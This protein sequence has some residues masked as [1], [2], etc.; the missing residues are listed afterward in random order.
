MWVLPHGFFHSPSHRRYSLGSA[1]AHVCF[2][3]PRHRFRCPILACQTPAESRVAIAQH[4]FDFHKE[5]Q[6]LNLLSNADKLT[7]FACPIQGCSE[8]RFNSQ[9]Y[10]AH[11][12]SHSPAELTAATAAL[13]PYLCSKGC[14]TVIIS[15][16][17][18]KRHQAQCAGLAATDITHD[19]EASTDVATISAAPSTSYPC[20][21]CNQVFPTRTILR[22]HY[23]EASCTAIPSKYL[24]QVHQSVSHVS[25]TRPNRL[26][27][28]TGRLSRS[29]CWR[30]SNRGLWTSPP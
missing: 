25:P 12:E 3:M 11:L 24:H 2:K 30:S 27:Q 14:Q 16:D 22:T 26:R 1:P 18:R 20:P 13:K 29:R 7:H 19:D 21:S 15:A 8:A 6:P 10:Q 5:P 9:T 4:L 28:P 23:R 17:G